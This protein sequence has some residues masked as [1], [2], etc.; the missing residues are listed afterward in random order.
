MKDPRVNDLHGFLRSRR[1]IRKFDH[2]QVPQ[3]V[4]QRILET[5]VHAPS[6]FNRQPWR[7]VV[8]TR[9]E[10]KSRLAESV[11]E[12]FR[13][14]L[15]KHKLGDQ[16]IANRIDRTRQ[17]I[18]ETPALIILCR[19][20]R[21]HK[22]AIRDKRK[23]VEMVMDIQSVALAGMQLL[24]AAH[25]EGLGA[26]WTGGPLFSPE[27]TKT[28]LDFP[29]DWQPQAMILMGYPAEEPGPKE[30]KELSEVARMS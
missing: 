6:A 8:V 13:R 28:A 25:A 7:F 21:D 9:A 17:R 11:V 26:V 3:D 5:A 20:G 16:E 18:L 30:V 22:H 27:V 14:D 24:L 10:V 23:R 12:D 19:L 4:I 2:R 1:S 29:S 15:K